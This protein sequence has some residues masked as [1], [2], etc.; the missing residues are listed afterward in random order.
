MPP[1]PPPP[2]PPSTTTNPHHATPPAPRSV[3]AASPPPPP[4]LPPIPRSTSPDKGTGG[5]AAILD[6]VPVSLGAAARRAQHDTF[7]SPP[8]SAAPAP[9]AR[10]PSA[11]PG[12]TASSSTDLVVRGQVPAAAPAPPELHAPIPAT[13]SFTGVCTACRDA[14]HSVYA[15]CFDSAAPHAL[16]SPHAIDAASHAIPTS[17]IPEAL[18]YLRVPG[19][20]TT[21]APTSPLF[22]DPA[23]DAAATTAAARARR[24]D[25]LARKFAGAVKDSQIAQLRAAAHV[26]DAEAARMGATVVALRQALQRTVH[27]AVKAD[28]YQEKE[29]AR[30]VE[31]VG[32]MKEQVAALLVMV[33]HAEE[34]K[35]RVERDLAA[36]HATIAGK[37]RALAAQQSELRSR[38]DELHTAYKEYLS[39]HATIERLEREA[40]E[41]SG[42]ARSR[43]EV[44]AAHL[45]RMSRDFDANSRQLMAAQDRARQLEFELSA[46]ISQFNSV[47]D[48]R[49]VLQK[50][51]DDL[52]EKFAELDAK[53]LQLTAA[54]DDATSTLAAVQVKLAKEQEEHKASE[55]K[56]AAEVAA[57]G[58]RVE[59]LT[60]AK[61]QVEALVARLKGESEKLRMDVIEL[62]SAKS[63]LEGSV[64]KWEDK[65]HAETTKLTDSLAAAQT[66]NGKQ[67]ADLMTVTDHRERLQVQVNDMR[68]ALEREH[69]RAVQLDAE[70]KTLKKTTNQARDDHEA[71]IASLASAKTNLAADKKELMETLTTARHDLIEKQA[72]YADLEAKMD[73]Y[74]QQKAEEISIL[75]AEIQSLKDAL[76]ALTK[77]YTTLVAAHRAL[78]TAHKGV[79]G[80]HATVQA[81]L[82]KC[83]QD[84]ASTQ[85]HVRA[86]DAQV[87][88]QE[89][90]LATAAAQLQDARDVHTL[91]QDRIHTLEATSR[92]D[93]E[94]WA[95]ATAQRDEAH[96]TLTDRLAA[97]KDQYRALALAHDQALAAHARTKR[98][99]TR[100]RDA[101]LDESAA[102]SVLE[103]ALDDGRYRLD[104]ERKARAALERAAA[105]VDRKAAQWVG[106]KAEAWAAREHAW[107]DLDEWM[108]AQAGRLDDMV[109]LLG[110]HEPGEAAQAAGLD[111]SGGGGRLG[112]A[113]SKLGLGGAGPHRGGSKA[114]S[115]RPGRGNQL[116]VPAAIVSASA[117]SRSR[118]STGGSMA[119]A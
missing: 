66:R 32:A 62:R 70:L 102:R 103:M 107:T 79:Q 7:A 74:A 10:P 47:G 86:L 39:M 50:E 96:R 85:A 4:A 84:L 118:R 29:A 41:G 20:A 82:A 33:M 21:V 95:V 59:D 16:P 54:H 73:E 65:Y 55:Q 53:H 97:A 94:A 14:L 35:A 15:H 34:E 91:Q 51:H 24:A 101:L 2:P 106:A 60:S 52:V 69:A 57:L 111:E 90:Q 27:Y 67:A 113:N 89:R 114:L 30:L 64:A 17:P 22:V 110:I 3:K 71:Q 1:P 68:A 93:H 100:T 119:A 38:Q 61:A 58:K 81:T 13:T 98:D 44:L 6:R 9:P 36:A 78:E 11:S 115:A 31:D 12:P 43:A 5:R 87:A 40:L 105:R 25:A 88:N 48:A 80:E 72:Q 42:A 116:H 18:R 83:Q 26:K 8:S 108:H 109:R 76:A 56:R 112:R 77:Q 92:A 46:V 23:T 99:L 19:A 75:H 45:D 117:Q 63:N 104:T 28:E 37:D 49:F